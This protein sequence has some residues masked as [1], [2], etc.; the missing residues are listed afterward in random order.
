VSGNPTLE[1]R[2]RKRVSWTEVL[3]P[4]FPDFHFYVA[5]DFREKFPTSFA[6]GVFVFYLRSVNEIYKLLEIELIS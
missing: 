4:D 1:M 2:I 6:A 5:R 3:Q